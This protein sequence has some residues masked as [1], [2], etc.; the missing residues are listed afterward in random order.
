M[1]D[2]DQNALRLKYFRMIIQA[3]RTGDG[4]PLFPFLAG[5]CTWSGRKGREA[6]MEGLVKINVNYRHESTIVRL[7]PAPGPLPGS[8]ENGRPIRVSFLYDPGE[9]CMFDITEHNT[10]LFR[11]ELDEEGLIRSFYGTFPFFFEFWPV[12]D[13]GN[14]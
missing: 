10:L 1:K 8:D 2:T 3:W 5:D 6:V 14:E 11:M 13:E 12:G 9:I 7:G 4:S